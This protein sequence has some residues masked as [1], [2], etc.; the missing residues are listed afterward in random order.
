MGSEDDVRNNKY[1]S[2]LLSEVTGTPEIVKLRQEYCRIYECILS[3][4]KDKMNIYFTGSKAE[5]LD[6]TG[7]DFDFMLDI[8]NINDIAVSESYQDLANSSL[9]NKFL[10]I[11]DNISPGFALLQS[12]SEIKDAQLQQSVCNIDNQ[13]QYLSSK[14]YV[15][16]WLPFQPKGSLSK[17]QGP[18]V[19]TWMKY[20]DKN[21]SGDDRVPSIHCKAWPRLAQEWISRPRHSGW[22]SL[23]D[24]ESVITFGFH[25]VAVGHPRSSFNSLEWRISFSIAERTLVWSFNHTQ[26]QCYAILKLILKEFIKPNCSQRNRDVL[27][28]YFIKTFLFWQYETT[29]PS[30][31]RHEKIKE[32]VIYLVNNFCRCIQDGVLRHYF[33]PRFNLFEVKLTK[34]AQVEL[35]QLYS[36][37]IQNGMSIMAQCP[38]LSSVWSKYQMGKKNSQPVVC[39]LH[40]RLRLA[41]EE[42]LII[43]LSK[44]IMQI[45]GRLEANSRIFNLIGIHSYSMESVALSLSDLVEN[46][47]LTTPLVSMSLRCACFLV[48]KQNL[49]CFIKT[50]KFVYHW[51]RRLILV[52]TGVGI[53]SSELWF[54]TFLLKHGDFA[55]ALKHINNFLSSIQPYAL[56]CSAHRI[57]DNEDK[58]LLYLETISLRRHSPSRN[59]KFWLFNIMISRADYDFVPRAIQIEIFYSDPDFG[60]DF[61]PFTYAYYLMFICYHGLGQFD[62]RNNALRQLVDTVIDKERCC[63]L[64]QFSY[65][66]TGSCLLFVGQTDTARDLFLKSIHC[67]HGTPYDEYNSAY[68]YLSNT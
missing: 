53:S 59:T 9:P 50:N 51:L 52:D 16:S 10:I 66:V 15:E 14:V 40:T 11:T 47:S 64:R 3:T 27:C 25:L 6:L 17:I 38:S 13:H 44:L 31:W 28:S 34:D 60:I 49:Q 67:T 32:C 57:L 41:N 63:V 19:E 8:N 48:S 65:N 12:V 36:V 30:F 24:Y 42:T 46:G 45:Y 55:L 39:L 58:K 5:G 18:S 56:Y 29:D 33:L 2:N 7:S 54:A 35:L 43:T 20:R 62:R 61:S 1:L 4:N 68:H 26:M 23:I 21:T 22:P 37:V